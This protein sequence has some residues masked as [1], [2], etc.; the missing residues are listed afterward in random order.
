MEE[1]VYVFMIL[2]SRYVI[3]STP[4]SLGAS[5]LEASCDICRSF[6][7]GNSVELGL[8]GILLLEPSMHRSKVLLQLGQFADSLTSAFLIPK[9]SSHSCTQS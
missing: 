8:V 5:S 6:V 2:R 1:Q 3:K 7:A 4:S 9:S